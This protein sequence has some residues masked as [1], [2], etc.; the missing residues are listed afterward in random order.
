[1]Q[2]RSNVRS[3]YFYY[4]LINYDKTLGGTVGNQS[5]PGPV[6][7]EGQ[8]QGGGYGNGFASGYNGSTTAGFTDY[9]EFHGGVYQLY[10]VVPGT[11]LQ[12]A[13]PEGAPVSYTLPGTNLNN[14]N[15]LQF[16]ID[17]S[18][19]VVDNNG[20]SLDATTTTK[21]ALLIQWLQVNIVA[22]DVVPLNP[23]L[24]VFKQIDSLGNNAS[25]TLA[26]TYLTLP[27]NQVGQI[28][29]NAD[30]TSLGLSSP[31]PSSN[32]VYTTDG[33]VGD[34]SLDLLDNYTI[35]VTQ[36]GQ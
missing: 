2:F 27:M 33:S 8:L 3:D 25:S 20:G 30:A 19:I 7:I 31:E 1:M 13:V 6:P 9:V 21:M 18:Q 16:A 5:A 10:H 35:A 29:T 24:P 14:T 4:F 28:F 15:T 36:V 12:Q 17:L 23:T 32:D 11:N 26:N 22:T 34:P